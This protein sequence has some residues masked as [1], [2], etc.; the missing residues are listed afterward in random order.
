[1]Y[2]AG[3]RDATEAAPEAAAV[4]TDLPLP[5]PP[6]RPAAAAAV[7][8]GH[9][10]T[11][12]Q[13]MPVTSSSAGLPHTSRHRAHL[14]M[15]TEHD[16]SLAALASA[17]SSPAPPGRSRLSVSTDFRSRLTGMTRASNPIS[18]AAELPNQLAEALMPPS[19]TVFPPTQALLPPPNIS[20]PPTETLL[21]P[22]Q[23]LLP[24][25]ENSFMPTEALLPPTALAVAHQEARRLS[26]M[27]W[28]A[29]QASEH[30]QIPGQAASDCTAAPQTHEQNSAIGQLRKL[31]QEHRPKSEGA[32]QVSAQVIAPMLPAAVIADHGLRA[33]AATSNKVTVTA[34]GAPVKSAALL[35]SGTSTGSS[36]QHN[37]TCSGSISTGSNLQQSS[38][39]S[40]DQLG[41]KQAQKGAATSHCQINKHTPGQCQYTKH[42]SSF[43][44][45]VGV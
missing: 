24:P 6:P 35:S 17:Y 30:A 11:L 16:G 13:P 7:A 22:I 29:H 15:R 37:S 32:D 43:C 38:C 9:H 14:P 36:I 18:Q 1:M 28:R 12:H 41:S 10:V 25:A 27:L 3:R 40:R 20:F 23:G 34:A 4:E 8:T 5:P 45:Q 26:D 2:C 33:A 19:E 44:H 31:G 39:R 21:P 42:C